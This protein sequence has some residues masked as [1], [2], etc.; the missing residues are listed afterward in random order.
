[1][2]ENIREDFKV[3]AALT[4]VKEGKG[5]LRA[6]WI[7][8]T[9]RFIAAL[10]LFPFSAVVLYR[11]KCWLRAHHVPI[12]PRAVD[13]LN[14]L[15]WRVQI[16]DNVSVGPGF[17]IS[18]G[19]VMISG[20]VTVGRNCTL[21]PW[22]GFGLAHKRRTAHPWDGLIGPTVGDNVFVGVGSRAFGPIT[23][24]DN[25][26]IGANSVVIHD[27]PSDT[28]VVGSPARPVSADDPELGGLVQD[29][30]D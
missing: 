4:G 2:F 23:I 22:S 26:R 8:D 16:S 7:F 11:F 30:M 5:I 1:M 20:Q 12:L 10:W 18:H 9:R 27:V 29:V 15:V 24:G 13:W 21:N 19:E 25:V 28:V 6:S 3:Y 14:M 17:C